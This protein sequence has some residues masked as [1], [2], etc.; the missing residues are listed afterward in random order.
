MTRTEALGLPRR[1]PLLSRILSDEGLTKKAYL[2]ALA[3]G[4]DYAVRIVVALVINPLIVSGMGDFVF[5]AW[6]VLG[7]VVGYASAAGGRPTQTL[8]WTIANLQNSTADVK[9]RNVGSAVIVAL[10]FLPLMVA[11][12]AVVTI[13]APAMLDTPSELVLPVRIAC[14]LLVTNLILTNLI[15]IPQSVLQGENLGYKRMGLSAILLVAGG[16]STAAAVYLRWGIVGLSVANLLV[17][18]LTG[19]LFLVVVRSYVPW[20]GVARPYLCEVRKF[21]DLSVWFL[22]WRFIIRAMLTGDLVVLGFACSAEMVTTYSL[23][24]YGCETM[25]SLAAILVAA[26]APGLGGIIGAGDFLRARRIR[27]E[28]MLLTWLLVMVMGTPF[29]AWNGLFVRLWVG[30]SHYSGDASTLLITIMMLQLILVRNDANIIDLTLNLRGKVLLGGASCI[31]CFAV[32]WW[33]VRYHQWNVAGICVGFIVG[34]IL[35]T[36]GYPLLIGKHLSIPL[37]EQLRGAA[38][39]ALATAI[40]FSFGIAL[41]FVFASETGGWLPVDGWLALALG[42]A[43]TCAASGAVAFYLGLNAVQRRTIAGRLV[44]VLKKQ[45]SNTGKA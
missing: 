22:L 26:I 36:V 13:Y 20:F 25:I 31:A 14:V 29:L 6:R 7:S 45:A 30:E 17:T 4:L 40:L 32:S 19:G 41:R 24:K 10:L 16:A 43:V 23:T 18:V 11:V 21:L 5:G 38:R 1:F 42:A 34:R 8:K 35:L 33:L 27:T 28:I 44:S 9:R 37:L 12:G 15:Y 39:P 3:A 2:N